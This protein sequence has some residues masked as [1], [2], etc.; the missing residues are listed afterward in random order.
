MTILVET[1]VAKRY[2]K[3]S[4]CTYKYGARGHPYQIDQ[5]KPIAL[6][7]ELLIE[8]IVEPSIKRM[9]PIWINWGPNPSASSMD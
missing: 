2:P 5:N 6:N 8:R 1:W 7:W 3:A 9:Q 4:T